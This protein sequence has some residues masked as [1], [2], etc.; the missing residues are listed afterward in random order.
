MQN[1]VSGVPYR[2]LGDITS[3][4][5]FLRLGSVHSTHLDPVCQIEKDPH[6][7]LDALP[8]QRSV[9]VHGY[10]LHR[11]DGYFEDVLFQRVQV[12]VLLLE[13]SLHFRDSEVHIALW[14]YIVEC[15]RQ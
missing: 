9:A 2:L 1:G 11:R 13:I 6:H 5:I 14:F 10:E 4:I 7:L 3:F 15:S 12:F 8:V